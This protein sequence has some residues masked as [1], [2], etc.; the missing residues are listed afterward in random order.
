MEQSFSRLFRNSRFAALAPGQVISTPPAE[1]AKGNYGLKYHLHPSNMS[2]PLKAANATTSPESLSPDGIL[3]GAPKH[4]SVTQ[5]D[6]PE[7]SRLNYEVANGRVSRLRRWKELYPAPSGPEPSARAAAMATFAKDGSSPTDVALETSVNQMTQEQFA[8]VLEHAKSKRKEFQA[9]VKEGTRRSDQWREFLGL[10]VDRTPSDIGGSLGS[11]FLR[12]ANES[13]TGAV[14]PPVYTVDVAAPATAVTDAAQGTGLLGGSSLFTSSTASLK[15]SEPPRKVWGRILNPVAG[16]FAVGIAGTVAYLPLGNLTTA[17]RSGAER[18]ELL[19]FWVLHASH[20]AQGRPEV[21]L[22][23]TEPPA[24]GV[25]GSSSSP[26]SNVVTKILNSVGTG[27]RSGRPAGLGLSEATWASFSQ[28][29]MS[30]D[31]RRTEKDG[32]R[33]GGLAGLARAAAPTDATKA[34]FAQSLGLFGRKDGGDAGPKKGE[35]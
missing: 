32:P 23:M 10:K 24:P 18:D 14:H 29:V 15:S 26:S 22:T 5:H 27:T 1:R 6:D 21:V 9:A 31:S 13:V 35:E 8:L 3:L 20:D 12:P 34:S 17:S 30:I 25:A 19:P 2:R 4:L 33:G 28:T 7:L 11:G 16:G